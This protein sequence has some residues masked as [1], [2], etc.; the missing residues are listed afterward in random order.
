MALPTRTAS[1]R[2]GDQ[3]E[4]I[5]HDIVDGHPCWIARTQNRDYGIDLEAELADPVGEKQRFQGKLVKIQTK[6]RGNI[7]R[8]QTRVAISVERALLTYTNEFKLPVILAAVCLQ[9][10]S[11]W[12]VWL[13]EWTML[14]QTRLAAR[15]DQKAVTI[16][17]PLDQTLSSGLGAPLQQIARGEG[18]SS[19][20]LALRDLL[21]VAIGWENRAIAEGVVKLLAEVH[22]PSR[23][24]TLQKTVD[25]L[26]GYGEDPPFWKAQQALPVLLSVV[27]MAGDTLTQDQLLRLVARGDTCSRTGLL[28]MG[29]LHDRWPEHAQSLGLP[30][31]FVKA[32]SFPAAWYAAMRERY[33]ECPSGV[34]GLTIANMKD[35]D[36]RYERIELLLNSEARDYIFAK[37][38]IRG[39]SVLTDC[40][41]LAD[42]K[43]KPDN[44]RGI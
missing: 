37:W 34:F 12:W 10:Q 42:D 29:R 17:I 8:Y 20:V 23:D 1:Q 7:R 5:V 14:N 30:R 11:I 32:G 6:T 33:P 38:P 35:A 13:Q 40:L 22:G 43:E 25:V 36:L 26:L 18:S 39:D 16:S 19:I 21:T 2:R 44:A 15:P 4:R 41:V 3:G 9:T 28:A 27:D 24:W 31:A